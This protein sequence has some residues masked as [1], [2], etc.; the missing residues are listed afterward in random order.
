VRA[1]EPI[2]IGLFSIV[3][4]AFMLAL[5]CI[6]NWGW[7]FYYDFSPQDPEYPSVAKLITF[8]LVNVVGWVATVAGLFG[9]VRK[10]AR[11]SAESNER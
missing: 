6:M 4:G 11:L 3:L 1:I 10:F 8:S 7:H 9:S 5:S 2:A